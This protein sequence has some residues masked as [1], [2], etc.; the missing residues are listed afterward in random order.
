MGLAGSP[1]W[2]TDHRRPH[3]RAADHAAMRVN[4]QPLWQFL[5]FTRPIPSYN[6]AEREPSWAADR[7]TEVGKLSD[8]ALL[9]AITIWARAFEQSEADKASLRSRAGSLV[10]SVAILTGLTSI[11]GSVGASAPTTVAVAT[12]AVAVLAAYCTV[13]SVFLAIR[14]HQVG[15]TRTVHVR[16]TDMT[17]VRTG[18]VSYAATLYVATR[19]N[20]LRDHELA[21]YLRDAQTYALLAVLL[22][23]ILTVIKVGTSLNATEVA[24][25]GN[26]G[27]Q[28]SPVVQAS[29]R[30]RPTE[31][32]RLILPGEV[33][34]ASAPTVIETNAPTPGGSSS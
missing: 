17:A 31:S 28:P 33:P 10:G 19:R 21:G 23:G 9:E 8:E 7:R 32:D 16:P 6:D 11:A 34:T 1:H 27:Y 2:T 3:K 24:S 12:I 18:R 29:P 20:R 4:G 25:S 5:A 14:V 26:G 13:A 15:M 22:V 30:E